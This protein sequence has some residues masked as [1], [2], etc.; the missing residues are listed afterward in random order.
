MFRFVAV[1]DRTLK[2]KFI[3]R[4]WFSW[5][6]NSA[7]STHY[8]NS[9]SHLSWSVTCAFA[10][11][12]IH[13]THAGAVIVSIDQ[14]DDGGNILSI[15]SGY[16]PPIYNRNLVSRERPGSL[17]VLAWV[18]SRKWRKSSQ[19]IRRRNSRL[20]NARIRKKYC[21]MDALHF[22]MSIS[23]TGGISGGVTRRLTASQIEIAVR[24]NPSQLRRQEST[25]RMTIPP[26]HLREPSYHT[27][28]HSIAYVYSLLK[29][30]LLF[31]PKIFRPRLIHRPTSLFS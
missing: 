7:K 8:S 18:N 29:N 21:S 23:V 5:T 31:I 27:Q 4:Q 28:R 6:H 10:H 12:Y 22:L 17:A 24:E 1:P 3:D 14:I 2:I 9:F 19:A 25:R 15:S 30:N 20:V 13:I 16:I 11:A 26:V